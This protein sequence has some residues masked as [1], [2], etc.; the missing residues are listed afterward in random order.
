MRDYSAAVKSHVEEKAPA[1]TVSSSDVQ[2][3][4]KTALSDIA[5]EEKRAQMS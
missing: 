1:T 4:V 2:I 5:D 3:A